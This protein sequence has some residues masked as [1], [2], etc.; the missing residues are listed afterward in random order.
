M[1]CLKCDIL[2]GAII[3]ASQYAPS[4][5]KPGPIASAREQLLKH[6]LS[7]H[8]HDC[9][10]CLQGEKVRFSHTV[11]LSICMGLVNSGIEGDE[12]NSAFSKL[13]EAEQS[14]AE[15]HTKCK[16]PESNPSFSPAVMDI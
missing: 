6:R 4:D 15:H 8:G 1:Y 14:M 11:A 9:L 5:E 16:C 2:G 12:R 10:V 13:W 3:T 7:E